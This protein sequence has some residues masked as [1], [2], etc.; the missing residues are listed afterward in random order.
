MVATVALAVVL[1]RMENVVVDVAVVVL[2]RTYNCWRCRTLMS[3]WSRS[4]CIVSQVLRSDCSEVCFRSNIASLLRAKGVRCKMQRNY[5]ASWCWQ[6]QYFLRSKLLLN[7]RPRNTQ[8]TRSR[9]HKG[10]Q[11]VVH[12]SNVASVAR[13][14]HFESQ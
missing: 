9:P 4:Y 12:P 1:V 2:L 5:Q 13:A 7:Y 14:V 8:H 11:M 3:F 10:V 6:H